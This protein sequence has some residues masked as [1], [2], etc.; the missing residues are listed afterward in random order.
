MAD[1]GHQLAIG[2]QNPKYQQKQNNINGFGDYWAN[3]LKFRNYTNGFIDY[4]VN[5][6]KIPNH[7]QGLVE[8][9]WTR[10]M[11]PYILVGILSL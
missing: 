2:S 5:I 6:L 11:K 3:V 10:T 9:S 8:L 1:G 7:L 4:V